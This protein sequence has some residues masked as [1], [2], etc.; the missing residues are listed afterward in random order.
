MPKT[1]CPF[2]FF[3]SW[4]HKKRSEIETIKYH[5]WPRTP[6]GKASKNTR[7]HNIQESQEVSLF[8]AD[9]HTAARNRQHSITKRKHETQIT[10]SYVLERSIRRLL[11]VLNIYCFKIIQYI[12]KFPSP[13]DLSCW[14]DVKHKHNNNNT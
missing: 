3:Q 10:R 7:T 1:I 9:D 14:W 8:P 11:E 4:G 6:R 5:T 13:Y 2:S 12:K